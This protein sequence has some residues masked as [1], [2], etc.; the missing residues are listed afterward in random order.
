MPR[1]DVE[2]ERLAVL[3]V[4]DQDY[5][6]TIIVQL[7]KRLGV[8]QVLECPNGAAALELLESRRPDVILCDIKMAPVDGLEF[9]RDVRG[10]LGGE[11][12]Q[13]PIIFLTSASDQATVHA[14]IANEVDGYLVKPV[15]GEHLRKKIITVL[16]RRMA[17]NG[18][19]WS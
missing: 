19:S 3:I 6:R 11:N 10:G 9:L 5:V 1:L 17:A 2:F 18:V 12:P 16:G 13:V 14:A 4:D 8:R 15:A 7:L